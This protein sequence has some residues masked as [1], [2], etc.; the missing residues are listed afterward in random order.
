MGWPP[1]LFFCMVG[2]PFSVFP[3]LKCTSFLTVDGT[4]FPFFSEDMTIGDFPPFC[5]GVDSSR[6]RVPRQQVS[7]RSCV[8]VTSPFLSAA[9]N[10]LFPAVQTVSFSR[11][12][13]AGASH[14]FSVVRSEY[15]SPF[16][17]LA[18]PL[19]LPSVL[20]D[21]VWFPSGRCSTSGPSE[22]W[23]Y[24]FWVVP[25]FFFNRRAGFAFH[26]TASLPG[27]DHFL[28][29]SMKILRPTPSQEKVAWPP[30]LGT[31]HLSLF[32]PCQKAWDSSP[33][34][35]D[36]TAIRKKLLRESTLSGA[37]HTLL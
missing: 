2:V 17:D 37:V 4:D 13:I 35:R 30:F 9:L 26:E 8:L 14:A 24:C 3:G 34:C 21:C 32:F 23:C 11:G 33:F 20:D 29:R 25:P 22:R 7:L 6:S 19:F 36:I 31:V 16:S 1:T 12:E 5:P 10:P 27:R 18:N 28:T 15:G